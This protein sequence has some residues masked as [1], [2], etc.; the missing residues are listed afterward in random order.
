MYLVRWDDHE[1]NRHEMVFD[2]LEDAWMEAKALKSKFDY[3]EI[4]ITQE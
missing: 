3:V 1:G 2:N 4:S